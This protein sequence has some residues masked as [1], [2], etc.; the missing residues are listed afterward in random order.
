MGGKDLNYVVVYKSTKDRYAVVAMDWDHEHRLG[1]RWFWK[2]TGN[3]VS[4]RGA[5]P[6]WFVIPPSLNNGILSALP[7]NDQFRN[8]VDEFLAGKL[9]G[10]DLA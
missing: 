10:K 1:I 7:L 6:T 5:R 4:S 8:K 2:E 9:K 3:P